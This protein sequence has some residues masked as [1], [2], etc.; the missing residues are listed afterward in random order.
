MRRNC[1]LHAPTPSLNGRSS[2][3]MGSRPDLPASLE[4]SAHAAYCAELWNNCWPIGSLSSPARPAQQWLRAGLL[5]GPCYKGPLLPRP[6]SWLARQ[7]PSHPELAK[8]QARRVVKHVFTSRLHG[9]DIAAMPGHPFFIRLVVVV[10]DPD[11]LA[12]HCCPLVM[13]PGAEMPTTSTLRMRVP[14]TLSTIRCSS[15]SS[16]VPT[17][18]AFSAARS[19]AGGPLGSK[20]RTGT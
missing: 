6:S 8:V 2:P 16:I 7:G 19:S 20:S 9:E 5:L 1:D 3:V 15:A 18:L 14:P 17:M 13:P 4:T 12:I 10:E 11:L